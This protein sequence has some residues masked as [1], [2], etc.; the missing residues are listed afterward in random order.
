MMPTVRRIIPGIMEQLVAQRDEAVARQHLLERRHFA[1]SMRWHQYEA[2][3][4]A[5]NDQIER[6]EASAEGLAAKKQ[7]LEDSRR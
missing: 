5:Y 3:I 1:Q 4:R 6:L 2:E 7:A